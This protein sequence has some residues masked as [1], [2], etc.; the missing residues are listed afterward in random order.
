MINGVFTLENHEWAYIMQLSHITCRAFIRGVGATVDMVTA[1]SFLFA[2]AG[3][4]TPAVMV[5]NPAHCRLHR[6]QQANVSATGSFT[7][8]PRRMGR[9]ISCP[10]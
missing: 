9:V 3:D 4:T 8:S 7:V 6:W 1:S 2:C 5:V 10:M